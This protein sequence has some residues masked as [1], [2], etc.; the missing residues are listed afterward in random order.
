MKSINKQQIINTVPTYK[1]G[2]G[3][4]GITRT[5]G[6]KG[7]EMTYHV[8]T[9]DYEDFLKG[10]RNV[11]LPE[12]T[13][14][15]ADP[16][17]YRSDFHPEDIGTFMNVATA[18]FLNRGSV[19]QDLH[20]LKDI[21]DAS[22]GN[23]SWKD[24]A[25]SAILGNSGVFKNPLANLALDIAVPAASIGIY[26]LASLKNA[27]KVPKISINTPE[28][29]KEIV[30]N[31]D[32]KVTNLRNLKNQSLGKSNT[33]VFNHNN[34]NYTVDNGVDDITMSNYLENAN[35]VGKH[36]EWYPKNWEKYVQ[37][38]R[39]NGFR[40]LDQQAYDDGVKQLAK[41][42]ASNDKLLYSKDFL[43]KVEAAAKNEGMD[44]Y[45]LLKDI[46]TAARMLNF[47]PLP[48][49]PKY[50]IPIKD[51]A[52][53]NFSTLNKNVS[54]V[55]YP[56]KHTI[57]MEFNANGE[58]VSNNALYTWIHE[59]EHYFQELFKDEFN[60]K[61]NRVFLGRGY[62]S[63]DSYGLKFMSLVDGINYPEASQFLAEKGSTNKENLLPYYEFFIKRN[64]DFD[65][66]DVN[67]LIDQMGD[68]LERQRLSSTEYSPNA[69]DEVYVKTPNNQSNYIQ[70]IEDLITKYKQEFGK[71]P[72]ANELID[73]GN[74]N[75]E[76]LHKYQQKVPT[77]PEEIDEKR[78]SGRL[79][80]LKYGLGIIPTAG[81]LLN[82]HKNGG[83]MK[84][85]FGKSGIHIKKQ[86]EGK[87]TEY[88][89]GKVTQ[90][91][92]NK[93]KASGNSKLVKRAV[94][95]ENARRW[96]HQNGG[97]LEK[98]RQSLKDTYLNIPI[99]L[100]KAA[101]NTIAHGDPNYDYKGRF[102]GG[103]FNGAG[104]GGSW[105]TTK[106]KQPT[107][108]NEA[109]DQ[110]V[111]NKQKTF[112]FNGLVYNTKHENNPVRETNNRIIGQIRN[113]SKK[114]DK[115][116]THMAGPIHVGN[117]DAIPMVTNKNGGILKGSMGMEAPIDPLDNSFVQLAQKSGS[118]V[119][120]APR[121]RKIYYDA[122]SNGATEQQAAAAT[123]TAAFES[124]GNYLA[125][126]GKYKGL[127]QWDTVHYP[128]G[129]SNQIKALTAKNKSQWSRN[130]YSQFNNPNSTPAGTTRV[131]TRDFIRGGNPIT[132]SKVATQLFGMTQNK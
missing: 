49:R 112:T 28:S 21:Y 102:N 64:K 6:P 93:A 5:V 37:M 119:Q 53:E 12:T 9:E 116:Y 26:K 87:F 84:T 108:F 33:R 15:A 103:S 79:D 65:Y 117:L 76:F 8:N 47:K 22:T 42:L 130:G 43:S 90:D 24:V 13:V 114:K 109:F 74:K 81:I 73:Y 7:S 107:N 45:D 69:Y 50:E 18:G 104:A 98:W 122:K 127:G 41:D 132:R 11:T 120:A 115:N 25:D 94:F 100:A 105:T 40:F 113:K 91:C 78:V 99:E 77:I 123:I 34:I 86:N 52:S 88:C 55:Y 97:I 58:P 46:Q 106:Q 23:K 27:A 1:S 39:D 82:K 59:N 80:A 51:L 96:K 56:G 48:A 124:H 89:G 29:E 20:L 126:N 129:Y 30:N 62:T 111:K 3:N 71:E 92:I 101:Y 75:K 44:S 110:A 72:Y 32:S 10:N 14:T 57:Y 63:P 19:S 125:K 66:N 118:G 60:S 38:I 4:K 128:R 83:K 68:A 16:K 35:G 95:A 54:G 67:N 121:L 85:F 2:S 31:F 131:Y 36:I 61:S 70:G 17:N